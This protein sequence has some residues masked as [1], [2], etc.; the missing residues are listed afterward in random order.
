M[1][2]VDVNDSSFYLLCVAIFPGTA[3]A[4]GCSVGEGVD[5]ISDGRY[6][7]TA[8]TGFT[9]SNICDT[10]CS[11]TLI[12]KSTPSGKPLTQPSVLGC[13]CGKPQAIN[14]QGTGAT[15]GLF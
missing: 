6:N 4:Q 3:Y 7:R 1:M 13:D 14:C 9:C 8:R 5:I 15:E 2:F 10:K 11:Q 12:V